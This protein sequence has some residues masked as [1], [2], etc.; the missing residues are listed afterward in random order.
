LAR[1]SNEE[2]L[3]VSGDIVTIAGWRRLKLE[4]RPRGANL[5]AG[6]LAVHLRS[7]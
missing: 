7:H 4:Q 3:A 2:S 5:E 1:H 6:A